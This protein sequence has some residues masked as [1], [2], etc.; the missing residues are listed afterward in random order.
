[1]LVLARM[2][3]RFAGRVA[4]ILSQR[5][6]GAPH[7]VGGFLTTIGGILLVLPGFITDI[8]GLLLLIPAIQRRLID[9]APTGRHRPAGRVL[10]LDRSQ[11]RDLPDRHIDTSAMASK[12]RQT[13]RDA[14][15]ARTRSERAVDL[16]APASLFR[17]KACVSH[18]A[19]L[20]RRTASSD[21][22]GHDDGESDQ[23]R[24]ANPQTRRRT[25]AAQCAGAIYQ[26]LL[27]RESERA[28]FAAAVQTS[29]PQ[30]NIQINVNAKPL[31]SDFEIELK[32]EG[33][34]EVGSTLLFASTS[35]LAAYS[36][37]RTSRRTAC[38]RS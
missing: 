21:D 6:F 23:W 33:K 10:D 14:D 24:P 37:S 5:D 35:F 27:V 16:G 20:R 22:A 31:A 25:A 13:P 38:T 11:W 8:V 36:G 29:S 4:D 18:S 15:R 1:M 26:G 7:P 34:A 3:R 17:L 19:A 28:A 9:R 30:I 12:I 32:I 2:G